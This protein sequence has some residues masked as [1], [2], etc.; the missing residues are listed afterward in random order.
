MKICRLS[1]FNLK[2]NKREAA[3]IVFLTFVTS[4]LM[5]VFAVSITQINSAFDR[6]F[7]ETGSA[8]VILLFQAD[9]Y[10]DIYCDILEKEYNVTD[11]RESGVLYGP[12]ASAI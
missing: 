8:D 11:V 1:L 10:R 7:E 2:R 12:G 9:K 4:F 3:A 5:A 6:A